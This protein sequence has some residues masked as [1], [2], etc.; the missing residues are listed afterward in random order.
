MSKTIHNRI[1]IQVWSLLL[2][3][4][5]M[6]A[7]AAQDYRIVETDELL[8]NPR[9][10]WSIGVIFKD[11]LTG[12]PVGRQI[13][14]GGKQYI[15]FYTKVLGTCYAARSMLAD[16]AHADPGM[17]YLFK[18]TVLNRRNEFYVVTHGI[19]PA[20]EG[21][22]A[23]K[24]DMFGEDDEDT[25]TLE[26]M[27]LRVNEQLFAYAEEQH[28]EMAQ[29]L[30]P[31]TETFDSALN[32]IQSVVV[33]AER[34]FNT[35]SLALLSEIILSLFMEHYGA[36]AAATAEEVPG[37]TD[38]ADEKPGPKDK[39]AIALRPGLRSTGG[40]KSSTAAKQHAVPR[41]MEGIPLRTNPISENGE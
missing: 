6:S 9:H 36:P 35:T 11:T 24:S 19:T 26:T 1:R 7:Y 15:P 14:I 4:I 41:L 27:L 17:E 39:P 5:G 30:Q 32:I 40:S 28:I 31:G 25:D 34:E 16:L 21:V 10:Y 2:I 29:L 23:L 12:G 18:G 3:I 8:E 38:T 33:K 20:V 37:V 13:R 22:N